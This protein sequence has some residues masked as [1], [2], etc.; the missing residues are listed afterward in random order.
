MFIPAIKKAFFKIHSDAQASGTF[1]A[2]P[3]Y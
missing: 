1:F 2:L 3:S